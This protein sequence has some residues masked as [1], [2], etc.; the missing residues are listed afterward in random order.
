M[1]NRR[2]DHEVVTRPFGEEMV[3]IYCNIIPNH[4][5]EEL[6][7]QQWACLLMDMLCN[8]P[9]RQKIISYSETLFEQAV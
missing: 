6:V 7:T 5:S 4:L 1:G 8:Y 2:S 3:N 9:G